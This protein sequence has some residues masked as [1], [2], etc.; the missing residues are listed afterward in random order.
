MAFIKL[1]TYG[2]LLLCQTASFPRHTSE[3]YKLLQQEHFILLWLTVASP[4]GLL[5]QT[6][7]EGLI[8][9]WAIHLWVRFDDHWGSPPT[10]NI[11]WFSIATD[12]NSFGTENQAKKFHFFIFALIERTEAQIQQSPYADSLYHIHIIKLSWMGYVHGQSFNKGET[13]AESGLQRSNPLASPVHHLSALNLLHIN[14]LWSIVLVSYRQSIHSLV[15]VITS[16][17]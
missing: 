6:N 10:Q 4:E 9:A 7:V 3:F 2:M 1:L 16:H 14:L 8:S 17:I 13:L 5:E 12:W 15:Q 11:L